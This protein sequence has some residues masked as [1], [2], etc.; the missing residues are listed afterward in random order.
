M[1]LAIMSGIIGGILV[2]LFF[3]ILSL[4]P[5]DIGTIIVYSAFVISVVIFICS[6]WIVQTIR[7]EVSKNKNHLVGILVLC[8]K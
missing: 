8:R 1:L 3:A 7:D 6:G 4:N 5:S 2:F